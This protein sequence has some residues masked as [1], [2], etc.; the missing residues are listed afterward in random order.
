[1]E[2]GEENVADDQDTLPQAMAFTVTFDTGR[3]TT[4]NQFVKKHIRNLSLPI[5]KVYDNKVS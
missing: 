5:S 2:E 1:M 3:T 4:K